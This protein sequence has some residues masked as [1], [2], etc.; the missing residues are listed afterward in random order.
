MSVKS[1]WHPD[2]IH[3][4]E[5][6]KSL[7]STKEK[8]AWRLDYIREWDRDSVGD[9]PRKHCRLTP[10]ERSWRSVF[11]H[12]I[13]KASSSPGGALL[14]R[15]SAS[16]LRERA[17]HKERSEFTVNQGRYEVSLLIIMQ[18][19]TARQRDAEGVVPYRFSIRLP[20]IIK[21]EA[22][23]KHFPKE[24]IS[25]I[26]KEWISLPVRAISLIAKLWISLHNLAVFDC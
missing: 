4:Y 3:S 22:L 2:E 17:K 11:S 12:L 23:P 21:G 16:R 18:L 5:W 7:S 14:L 26:P 15:P 9:D 8:E 13:R 1:E 20:Y 6:M 25:L 19:F 24:N 10:L